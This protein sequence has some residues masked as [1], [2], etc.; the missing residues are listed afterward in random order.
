MLRLNKADAVPHTF[1]KADKAHT[2]YVWETPKS[3]EN[4]TNRPLQYTTLDPTTFYTGRGSKGTARLL[5]EVHAPANLLMSALLDYGDELGDWG[6]QNAFIQNGWREPDTV[7]Q[8]VHYL[9]NIMMVLNNPQFGFSGLQFPKEL[10]GDAE[11]MLGEGKD[12]RWLAFKEKLRKYWGGQT[13]DVLNK[14]AQFYVPRGA[15][16]PHATG[17][18]F[19]LNFPIYHHVWKENHTLYAE[20]EDPVDALPILNEA[21][22]R[23]ATGMWLNKYSMLFNFDSYNTGREIW[24]MEWR[25]P[26]K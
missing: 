11:G 14:V 25:K 4:Y 6:I 10:E 17:L 20:E 2:Y 8:G 23:S 1:G 26:N 21:A 16:N 7:E 19:D 12:S 18:V 5:P 15:F 3:H 22:L 24:H 9:E 13:D